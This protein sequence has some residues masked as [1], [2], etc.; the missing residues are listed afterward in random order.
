MRVMENKTVLHGEQLE[1]AVR[2]INVAWAVLPGK[3]LVRVVPMPGFKMGFALVT[4]VA[5]LAEE[6]QHDPEIMLRRN[7]VEITLNTYETGGITNADI[8]MAHAVDLLLS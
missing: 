4:R 8:V 7:E 2:G 1:Q 6:S 5:Q 3:G